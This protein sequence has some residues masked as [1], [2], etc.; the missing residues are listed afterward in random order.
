MQARS[1]AGGGGGQDN[2][3]DFLWVLA[4]VIGLIFVVWYVFGKQ[5]VLFLYQIKLY[6]IYFISFLIKGWDWLVARLTFLPSI[7]MQP[8]NE[9]KGYILAGQLDTKYNTVQ[10]VLTQVGNYVRY[11]AILIILGIAAW[12]YSRNVRAKFKITLSISKMKELEKENWPQITPTSEINLVKEDINTGPWAMA[13]TS[14]QFCKKHQLL[15]ERKKGER[16]LTA[17]LHRGAAQQVFVLQLGSLW[18]RPESL[19]I[20]AKAL[21]AAFAASANEDRT[22]ATNLLKQINASANSGKLNFMGAEELLWKYINTKVVIRVLQRH[23]YF[24]TVFASMLELART[25]GVFPTSEFLWLKPLDRR[26]WY[27][28][29]SVGRQTAVPEIAGAYAHWLAEKSWGAPLRTPMV[30]EAVKALE[31]SLTEIIYEE[32]E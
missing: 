18:T 20:Y 15:K 26:L 14:L 27:M 25:D 13:M 16:S 28:L 30:D 4:L 3:Y 21:F 1:P 29:N 11:P 12:T 22:S 19:P 31:L 7:H 9:I 32:E 23:A 2:A 24:Y 17:E 10:T 5:I 6:E 8:L